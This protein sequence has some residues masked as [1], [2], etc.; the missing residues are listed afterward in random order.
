MT[1]EMVILRTSK[2][3][4]LI[5]DLHNVGAAAGI[6]DDFADAITLEDVKGEYLLSFET[7]GSM[8]P[9]EALNAAFNRLAERFSAIKEDIDHVIA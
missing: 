1:S 8:T 9:V 4:D 2:V 6:A 3:S 7:D 5:K